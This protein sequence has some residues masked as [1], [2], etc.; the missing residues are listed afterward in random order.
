VRIL[1]R[2]DYRSLIL[3][4]E[5]GSGT[6]PQEG[7]AL[8]RAVLTWLLEKRITSIVATHYPELK[9]YAHVTKGA[10][11]ASL[12]FDLETLRPTYRLTIGLPGRSNALAI[13]ERLGL[14]QE[15]ID[16]ARQDI[17]PTELGA[18]DLLDEIRRQRDLTAESY[19]L[20][21]RARKDA[22]N[23]R[24]QLNR[25]LD[26]IENRKDAILEATQNKAEEEL[27]AMKQELRDLRRVLARLQAAPEKKSELAEVVEKVEVIEKRHEKK[28]RQ[29]KR[30]PRP[31]SEKG[32]LKV[33]EKVI[34]R[35]LGTEAVISA[36]DGDD[37]EV[38][39]GVL[40][41]RLRAEDL[42]R[43][44]E[45]APE[46]ATPEQPQ[47]DQA[48]PEKKGRTRLPAVSMP[49]LELDLRGK[50]VDDGLDELKLWLERG[51]ASGML[52]GRV[53]HGHGTGAMKD[54][55]REEL[56]HSPFIKRWD[57]GGEKEGGDGVSVVF[58]DHD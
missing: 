57:V 37:I 20:A 29:I 1:K 11:N 27:E 54:A 33:G 28:A 35:K 25:R 48:K 38:Q 41:L 36:I 52:F 2:A 56:R 50:R 39:A 13:A 12:E 15:I 5:L 8:A 53:I 9:A 14:K 19:A 16:M 10:V 45:E 4:D 22:E 21:E 58:F 26:D 47:P 31:K 55:V 46:E 51:F 18:D 42:R 23:T 34:V 24:N 40:R 43:K 17:D 44:V 32:P 30:R 6:D 3:L 49:A 7:S